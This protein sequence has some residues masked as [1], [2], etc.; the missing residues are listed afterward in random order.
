VRVSTELVDAHNDNTIWADSYDRDLTDIF[1]IQSE[2]AQRVASKLSAQLSP[3]ERRDIDEKPTDN[4]EAYDLYLQAKELVNNV[5]FSSRER[6]NYTRAIGLLEQAIQKDPKFALA[7]C[8]IAKAHDVLCSDQLEPNPE[9]RALGDA[10]VNEALRLRPDLSEVHLAQAFHLYT[11]YGDFERARVQIAIAAQTLANNSNLI[12]LVALIDE[13]Q[14]KWEKATA[15]LQ[16]AVILDPRNPGL[17]DN[18]A[19]NYWWLR[20]YRDH[21]RIMDRLIELKPG[22][23]VF[24]LRKADSAF[25]ERADLQGARAAYEAVS[26]SVK[27][28]PQVTLQRYYYATCARDFAAAKDI[29][30]KSPN[31]DF[32]FVG[33][34]VPR[35]VVALWL[36]FLQGNH[37][38]IEEFGAARNQLDQ[39][40]AADRTNPFLMTALALADIALGHREDS[41]KEGRWA[42][43]LRPISEDAVWGP[44]IAA[45]VAL[46]D[47]WANQPDTAFEQLNTL[48][49]LPNLRLTY[50]DLKTYPG[51]D[52]L[53]KDPRF[54][55]LLTKL[56]PRD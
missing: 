43:E 34:T 37:P 18:L 54:E 5:A 49:Q 53:R 22:Q 12:E 55:K 25:A 30:G 42:M 2:I 23:S 16:R 11:C 33:A 38:T 8:L 17:L 19:W 6:E 41:I 40:V 4:L 3:E 32:S 24:P 15:G 52:P 26:S 39:K 45:N 20:R 7:Y 46:V 27:D 56:A 13:G 50:G 36:E 35:P 10:A 14:G 47:V 48:V 21:D 44:V 31:E 9:G 51:W 29:I 28:D 1:A